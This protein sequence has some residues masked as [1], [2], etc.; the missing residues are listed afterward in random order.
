MFMIEIFWTGN[1]QGLSERKY[2]SWSD[3]SLDRS[4]NFF[5]TIWNFLTESSLANNRMNHQSTNFWF[6]SKS[7][8]KIGASISLSE[9]Q[10]CA[11]PWFI[12]VY[13]IQKGRKS[14]RETTGDY[15]GKKG[16]GGSKDEFEFWVDKLEQA[17]LS[18]KSH[19]LE[20]KSGDRHFWDSI[21]GRQMIQAESHEPNQDHPGPFRP[22][23]RHEESCPISPEPW[24]SRSMTVKTQSERTKTWDLLLSSYWERGNAKGRRN[25]PTT[26]HLWNSLKSIA[27][28]LLLDWMINSLTFIFWLNHMR[29]SF[30][31]DVFSDVHFF[32]YDSIRWY[33]T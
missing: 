13:A 33:N 32:S 8:F 2:R 12:F 19:K 7:V 24:I 18:F 10:S 4:W 16:V 6:E 17:S 31:C 15:H 26:F 1:A 3:R 9:S 21:F 14:N 11:I 20:W 23:G 5:R 30:F 22:H 27:I 28:V 29:I 25:N